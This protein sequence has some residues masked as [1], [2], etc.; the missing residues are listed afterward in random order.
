M[1]AKEISNE[2][3]ME[4]LSIIKEFCDNRNHDCKDCSMANCKDECQELPEALG[5]GVV[6]ELNSKKKIRLLLISKRE[7]KL[8]KSI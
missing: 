6:H 1:S 2:K 8:T 7:R 4:S 5:S 3:L